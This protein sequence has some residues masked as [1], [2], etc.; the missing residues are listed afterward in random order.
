MRSVSLLSSFRCR[1]SLRRTDVAVEPFEVAI[2][3]SQQREFLHSSFLSSRSGTHVCKA[4]LQDLD[5]RSGASS[6]LRFQAGPCDRGE[7]RNAWPRLQGTHS[8]VK[9]LNTS[10]RSVRPKISRNKLFNQ[11]LGQTGQAR[12]FQ[13]IQGIQEIHALSRG[14]VRKV[15]AKCCFSVPKTKPR[16]PTIIHYC[17]TVRVP[18]AR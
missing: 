12:L 1:V 11:N 10:W 18:V 13:G 16:T 7:R 2:H 3:A 14:A 9:A 5:P 8:T 15:A 17:L 4:P 6:R